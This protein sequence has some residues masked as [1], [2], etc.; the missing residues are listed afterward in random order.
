MIFFNWRVKLKTDLFMKSL[1]LNY[2]IEIEEKE[3]KFLLICL[4]SI[5]SLTAS[6]LILGMYRNRKKKRL[7]KKIDDRGSWV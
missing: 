7:W 6:Y 3:C 4:R 1:I 5:T 2:G